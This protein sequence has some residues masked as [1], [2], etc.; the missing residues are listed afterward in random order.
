LP[1][2]E[3]ARGADADSDGRATPC[4]PGASNASPAVLIDTNIL[5]YA[6][7]PAEPRKGRRAEEVLERLFRAGTGRLAV[8]SLGEFVQA[9]T[10]ARRKLLTTTEAVDLV[11]RLI[12]LWPVLDLTPAIVVLAARGVRDHRFAYWDAQIWATARIHGIP[13]ILTED[14]ADGALIE[15][16]RYVNPFSPGFDLARLG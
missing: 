1:G 6:V 10:S 5:V 4:T 11:D 16:V 15:G 9:T 2:R 8:Q 3:H 12:R 13:A 14:G 7:D